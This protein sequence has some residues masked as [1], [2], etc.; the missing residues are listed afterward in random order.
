MGRDYSSVLISSTYQNSFYN[1]TASEIANSIAARHGFVPN[2]SPTSTM[3]GSYQCDDHSQ[4]LLDVH[5]PITNEWDLLKH[6]AQSE[7]FQL[8]VNSTML[9]FAPTSALPG[10]AWSVE[11]KDVMGLTFH[12]VCPTSDQT[13]LTA[14]SW[15]S[16]LNQAFTFADE[17]SAGQADYALS[18]PDADPG[19]E[20]AM[21]RPNLMPQGVEQL[22]NQR[23]SETNEQALTVQIV[24][25]GEM[26]FSPG[27][28]LTITSNYN[29]FDADY[30]IRSV[31]RRFSSAGGFIQHV[32]GFA[33]E[34]NLPASSE[35]ADSPNG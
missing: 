7:G 26:S 19:T 10:N 29:G 16:W 17:Q 32:H 33:K 4:I 23:L 3:V 11:A 1:Q 27:D 31:R 25:P 22:V 2:I 30:I 28:V 21:V 20:I 13:T 8:F 6:L 35:T 12:K 5:S 14:K 24:M 34:A 18:V 9:V 15:N